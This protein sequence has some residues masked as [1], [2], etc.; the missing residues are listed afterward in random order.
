MGITDTPD[1]DG[2]GSPPPPCAC[3]DPAAPR[4]QFLAF[5]YGCDETGGRYA[6]VTLSRCRE[7]R[8]IWLRYS[9][10][11]ESF[12]RSGRWAR[13]IIT[14]AQAETLT[15]ET[16]ADCLAGL[17][18]YLYGGSYFDGRSGRRKGSMHWAI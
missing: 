8:R 3:E 15:P 11:Y 14:E 13:G 4:D 16:A 2:L 6:D 9:V 18:W 7:C 1:D 10:E 12:S 17:D 5:Q